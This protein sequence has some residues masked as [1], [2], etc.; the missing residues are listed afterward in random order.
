MKI[1][2]LFKGQQFMLRLQGIIIGAVAA[3]ALGFGYGGWVT[4]GSAER[5]ASGRVTAAVVSAYAPVCVEKFNAGATPEQREG[6]D[7]ASWKKD[8]YIEETGFA[9]LPGSDRP[10]GAVAD[11]CAK[12]ITAAVDAAAEKAKVKQ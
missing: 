7:K 2:D 4:G 6:F 1:S 12:L 11:A 10:N 9:N 5:M 3:V 8:D